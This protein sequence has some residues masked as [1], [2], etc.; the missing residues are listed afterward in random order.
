M[1]KLIIITLLLPVFCF[2]QKKVFP[3]PDSMQY[4]QKVMLDTNRF[5]IMEN[6]K[7]V[8]LTA[9]YIPP[10]IRQDTIKT[11]LLVSDTSHGS[12][13]AMTSRTWTMKGYEVYET[14]FVPEHQVSNGDTINLYDDEWVRRF[15]TRLDKEKKQLPK[16]IMVWMTKNL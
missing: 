10:T 4:Y 7:K 8:Q 12:Y 13:T 16:S 6:G 1:K 15:V 14:V 2:G 11:I 3:N 5:Y 9:E